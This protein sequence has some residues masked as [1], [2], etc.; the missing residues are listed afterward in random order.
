MKKNRLLGVLYGF[1]ALG[2]IL[3]SGAGIVHRTYRESPLSFVLNV[4]N[5]VIWSALFLIHWKKSPT[6]PQQSEE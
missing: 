2:C 1:C 6:S 4:V 5:S 3:L